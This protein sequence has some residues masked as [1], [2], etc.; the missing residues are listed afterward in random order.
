MSAAMRCHYEVLELASR[1]ASADEVKKAYKKLALKWHPDRNFG[2][3]SLAAE[4]FKRVSAAYAVLSD[5]HERKWY[6][7]HR[8]S[9]LR[10]GDGTSKGGGGGGGGLDA[11]ISVDDLWQYFNASC[12]NGFEERSDGKG[13]YQVYG[14]IFQAMVQQEDE[15]SERMTDAPPFGN[16]SSSRA[17]VTLFYNYWTN[18]VTCLSFSWEDE[19]NPSDAPNRDVRRAIEKENKKAREVGRKKYIDVVRALVGYAKKRDPRM[20][21]IEAEIQRRKEEDAARRKKAQLD[22]QARRAD[23]RQRRQENG[24]VDDEQERLR[25]IEE[26]KGAYLLADGSSSDDGEDDE[27]QGVVSGGRRRRRRKGS[28]KRVVDE[29]DE[30]EEE[31]DDEGERGQEEEEQEEQEEETFSCEACSKA[32]KTQAQLDQ[33][34]Q[35]KVHRKNLK[36]FEKSNKSQASAAQRMDPKATTGKKMAVPADS[37]KKKPSPPNHVFKSLSDDDDDDGDEDD[38]DEEAVLRSAM[39]GL[40]ATASDDE[41]SDGGFACGACEARF[42]T[43]NSLFIH[44]KA[45]GHSLPPAPGPVAESNKKKSRRNKNSIS[46]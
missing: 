1:L 20:E 23:A 36:E 40:K 30:E 34:C 4:M 46:R 9:I 11:D 22:E 27:D 13:F 37:R 26:R 44:L 39:K 41:A 12:F 32:F 15:A 8:D 45:L 29:G 19:Y 6:D 21:A 17:D 7:D 25:R 5:P 28:A 38:D 10:G 43:R 35:S 31:D 14:A 3:E 42:E 24:G 33:H 18:F 16:E 2:Q